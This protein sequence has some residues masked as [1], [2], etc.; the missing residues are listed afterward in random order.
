MHYHSNLKLKEKGKTLGKKRKNT[1]NLIKI[2]SEVC[3]II[4]KQY[5]I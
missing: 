4:T 1:H 2:D 5:L 3:R